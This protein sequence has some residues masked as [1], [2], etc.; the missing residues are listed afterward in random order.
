MILKIIAF[1]AAAIPL[2]LFIR[3]M[4]FRRSTPISE[5]L[6]EFKKQANLAVSIFLLLIGCVVAFATAKLV[7]AWWTAGYSPHIGP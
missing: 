6:K 2:F 3:S 4:F 1:I 5:G 7:W